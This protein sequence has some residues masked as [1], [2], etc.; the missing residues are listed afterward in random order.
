MPEKDFADFKAPTPFVPDSI[1][2]HKEWLEAIRSGGRTTCNF[3][4]S[5]ALTEAALLG[6]VAYRVGRR[7]EWDS[8]RLIARNE[9]AAAKLIQHEYRN[10]WSL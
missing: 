8:E 6:N 2:H 3:D 4:Y 7:I 9:P 5:G 1:G 10:G